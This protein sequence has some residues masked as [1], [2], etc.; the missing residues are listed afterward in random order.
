MWLD[1][2]RADGE[3]LADFATGT[4]GIENE[5]RLRFREQSG[6]LDA[7]RK[8]LARML[9]ETRAREEGHRKREGCWR[10]RAEALV[11][12][13]EDQPG[14]FSLV[15]GSLYL[16]FSIILLAGDMVL[17]MEVASTYFNLDVIRAEDAKSYMDLLF[18]GD[19]V[20][21]LQSFGELVALTLAVLLCGMFLKV[22]RDSLRSDTPTG[23]RLEKILFG[24]L[25]VLALLAV[26]GMSFARWEVD[27]SAGPAG[28]LTR[29]AQGVSFLLGLALPLVSAGFFIKGYEAFELRYQLLRAH[30]AQSWHGA[31]AAIAS[32]RVRDAQQHLDRLDYDDGPLNT[33]DSLDDQISNARSEYQR[34]YQE[35]LRAL[36]VSGGLLERLKPVAI[37]RV[38]GVQL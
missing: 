17:L 28:G 15:K 37:G 21:L 16:L 13:R 32:R 22:W 30:C 4:A 25:L 2:G 20:G 10:Q 38:T 24:T 1:R 36:M 3:M 27:P 35:G 14:A 18:E 29:L 7:N 26:L 9:D 11:E 8:I 34:G 31:R 5:V 6:K 19:V 12:R 23:R 33:S